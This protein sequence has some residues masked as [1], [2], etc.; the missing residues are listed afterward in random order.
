MCIALV[1]FKSENVY[2]Q[3]NGVYTVGGANPDFATYDDLESALTSNG[4]SGPVT[5]KF[6][7]GTYYKIWFADYFYSYPITFESESSNAN[8][9]TL[10]A[11][12]MH[13]NNLIMKNMS[14]VPIGYWG[15][16]YDFQGMEIEGDNILIDS[17]I[18]HGDTS[19]RYGLTLAHNTNTQISN[20]KFYNLHW[21]VVYS[22]HT[23]YNNYFAG[24]QIIKN[25]EFDSVDYC[26][27]P[28]G[29]IGSSLGDSLVVTNNILKN[30]DFGI[31]FDGYGFGQNGDCRAAYIYNNKIYGK[32]SSYSIKFYRHLA[33]PGRFW[34]YNNW[35]FDGKFSGTS[36][37]SN[38]WYY[39]FG[40]DIEES[41]NINIANNSM[42]SGI[43]LNKSD[44]INI[45]NNSL[46]C[47]SCTLIRTCTQSTFSSDFNNYYSP[48]SD[49]IA[50]VSGN[51][52]ETVDKLAL[53]TLRE[54]NSI[55]KDPCFYDSTN[56]HSNSPYLQNSGTPLNEV[57]YD[58]DNELRDTVTPDIG[59]DEYHSSPLPPL[60]HF[61]YECSGNP[62][63]LNFINFSVRDTS[64]QWDF[65]DGNLSNTENPVHS[66]PAAGIYNVQLIANNMY[67]S[68]TITQNIDVTNIPDPTV[69]QS[70][71]TLIVNGQY[72][73]YQWNMNGNPIQGANDNYYIPW[74]TGQYSV[75]VADT[76]ICEVTSPQIDI[77]IA[78]DEFSNI[79]KVDIF[80]N[81]F[82]DGISIHIKLKSAE[83]LFLNIY[84]IYGRIIFTDNVSGNSVY[85]YV[86]E[87]GKFNIK[88]GLYFVEIQSS[89]SSLIEKVVKE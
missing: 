85:N 56:L 32:P 76:M 41:D 9:V 62:L 59:A 23:S 84:D 61:E 28:R 72:T 47:D 78:L 46:S 31:Y 45:F 55:S 64:Y 8:D 36:S 37:G 14:I 54:Q 22:Q 86:L 66:F 69:T 75:S 89:T 52:Y 87:T 34:I 1:I 40:I 11:K 20:C 74:F 29:D 10:Y 43:K 88:Q 5:F 7:P 80:P 44:N 63:E 58:F 33:H 38:I 83:K 73:Y 16:S 79:E 13:C 19:Y 25:C 48:N 60:S 71:D 26:I 42:I 67:D 21:G 68:D 3:L 12:T 18:I 15:V 30:F 6:R 24:Y 27:Y 65:N 50:Y 70:Q 57:L 2:S 53:Y 51:L 17:C 35:F 82:S 77:N 4:I 81:P 39:R 49:Y